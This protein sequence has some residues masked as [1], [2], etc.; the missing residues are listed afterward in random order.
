M[1][2]GAYSADR[3]TKPWPGTV[4]RALTTLHAAT[5][6]QFIMGIN[7]HAESPAVTKEQVQRSLKLL[8]AGSVESLAVGNEPDMYSLAPKMGADGVQ[9]PGSAM[10]KPGN[11]IR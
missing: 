1:R 6:T 11:W 3:M 4:Y 9:L 8:P 2:V 5:A 10:P 7:Q